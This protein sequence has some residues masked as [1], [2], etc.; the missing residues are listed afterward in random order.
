MAH[1]LSRSLVKGDMVS[2]V[3]PKA[4]LR[5]QR[6]VVLTVNSGSAFVRMFD[7]W[8]MEDVPMEFFRTI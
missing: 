4:T 8:T 7:G 3:G 2:Y 1:V 6:G 5:G